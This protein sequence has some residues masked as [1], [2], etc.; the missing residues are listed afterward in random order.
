MGHLELKIIDKG[1]NR[2]YHKVKTLDN[3][4]FLENKRK[5][6]KA[7]TSERDETDSDTYLE[8]LIGLDSL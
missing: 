5:N 7:G 8:R 2:K 1:S 4:W 3:C 6:K